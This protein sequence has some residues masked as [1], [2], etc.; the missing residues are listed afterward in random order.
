MTGKAKILHI[1]GNADA[2]AATKWLLENMAT[3]ENAKNLDEAM[4]KIENTDYQIFILEGAADGDENS[5]KKAYDAI[6]EK[7]ENAEFIVYSSDKDIL[8]K[9]E[10]CGLKQIEKGRITDLHMY[11]KSMLL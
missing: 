6:K 2:F 5:W 9:A 4:K 11:V 10:E 3:V 7:K 1:E 8:K